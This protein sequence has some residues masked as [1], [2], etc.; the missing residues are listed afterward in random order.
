MP[1]IDFLL[2][3][4]E[5][6]EISRTGWAARGVTEPQRVAGHTWGVAFLTFLFAPSEPDIDGNKAI[7]I[8]LIHDLAEAVTGDIVVNDTFGTMS[9]DEKEQ[10][11]RQAMETLAGTTKDDFTRFETIHELWDEYEDRKSPEAR[12]V[13]DM[14]MIEVCLFALKLPC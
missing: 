12:F 5:L 4:I 11:E 10:L 8:A 1:S 7:K 9:A 6:N 3:T 14:D 2:K 13:K